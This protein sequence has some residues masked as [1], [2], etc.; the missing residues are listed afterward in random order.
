MDSGYPKQLEKGFPGPTNL[1][2]ALLWPPLFFSSE[3]YFF[4]GSKY[5]KYPDM[6]PRPMSNWGGLPDNLDAAMQYSNGKSYFF[7]RS[8][9]Y[10]YN[11]TADS[12]SLGFPKE[13]GLG[14]FD[15]S[16]CSIPLKR[17]EDVG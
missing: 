1:D 4:K 5:W 15:C 9:Y 7:K 10:L 6:S 12:A 3:L 13:M 16:P 8:K 14:W 11:V 17:A 2:A